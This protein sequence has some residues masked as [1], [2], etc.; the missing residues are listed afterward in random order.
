MRLALLV[1]PRKV[2]LVVKILTRFHWRAVAL[3][4]LPWLS[5]HKFAQ[6]CLM[7]NG[8]PTDPDIPLPVPQELMRTRFHT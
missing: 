6:R 2:L 1:L 8:W 7:N 5:Y 3:N 4:G